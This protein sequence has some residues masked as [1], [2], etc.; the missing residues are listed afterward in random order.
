LLLRGFRA[1]SLKDGSFQWPFTVSSSAL[2][3]QLLHAWNKKASSGTIPFF[4]SS[5][6]FEGKIYGVRRSCKYAQRKNILF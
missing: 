3:F 4:L 5:L 1:F 6:P 2:T